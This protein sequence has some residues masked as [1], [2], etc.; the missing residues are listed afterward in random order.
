MAMAIALSIGVSVTGSKGG[1]CPPPQKKRSRKKY[2][3]GNYHVKFGHFSGKCHAKFGH[4][5]TFSY[6]FSGKI[7]CPKVDSS[8]AYGTF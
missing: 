6:I 3:S 5:V 7:Y 1:M 2:F 4:F 8:Y